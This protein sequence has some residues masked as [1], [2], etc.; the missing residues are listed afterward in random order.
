MRLR[1]CSSCRTLLLQ[2]LSDKDLCLASR[3]LVEVLLCVVSN[4]LFFRIYKLPTLFFHLKKT[5]ATNECEAYPTESLALAALQ[6]DLYQT[7]PGIACAYHEQVDKSIVCSMSR[8]KR[9]VYTIFD[10][11]CE[12]ANITMVPGKHL[13]DDTNVEALA[14]FKEHNEEKKLC[15][16][17]VSPF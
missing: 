7:S 6:R 9:W 10:E 17:N 5:L 14:L 15:K 13:P 3:G 16:R 12:S 1:S 8:A 4:D 2:S 11:C